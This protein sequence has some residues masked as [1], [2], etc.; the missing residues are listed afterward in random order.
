MSDRYKREWNSRESA[1]RLFEYM[2]TSEKV[3]KGVVFDIG[4]RAI[5]VICGPKNLPENTW[6]ADLF[7]NDRAL[8]YLGENVSLQRTLST[9]C[10]GLHG[11]HS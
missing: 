6:E 5:R 8:T 7:F 1:K 3:E 11:H 2:R 10:A 4:T 9:S